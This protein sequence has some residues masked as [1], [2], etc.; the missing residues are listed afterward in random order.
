MLFALP[1]KQVLHHCALPGSSESLSWMFG[2]HWR[3]IRQNVELYV[4]I[5]EIALDFDLWFLGNPSSALESFRFITRF[6][7]I[8]PWATAAQ[9]AERMTKQTQG[10]MENYFSWLQDLFRRD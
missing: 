2:R 3:V 8:Q 6:M 10:A 4:S 1:L 7:R 5:Y 9:T